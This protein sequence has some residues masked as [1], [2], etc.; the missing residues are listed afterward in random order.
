[1][2]DLHEQKRI[3]RNWAYTARANR[4]I[5]SDQFDLFFFVTMQN[6]KVSKN[7]PNSLFCMRDRDTSIL[8]YIH[9]M[10]IN[11]S[12]KQLQKLNQ[13]QLIN[14]FY[15]FVTKAFAWLLNFPKIHG[16]IVPFV[17]VYYFS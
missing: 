10:G 11:I 14:M 13:Y 15:A 4:E 8:L 17:L 6:V 12:E 2:P 7:I 5:K 3:A 9:Y 1:M 16:F